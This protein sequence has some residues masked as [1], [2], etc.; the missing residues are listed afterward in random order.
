MV[1]GEWANFVYT[2][3]AVGDNKENFNLQRKYDS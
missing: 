3:I 1:R 2:H